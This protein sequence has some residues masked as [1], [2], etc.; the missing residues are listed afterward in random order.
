MHVCFEW[1]GIA[2]RADLTRPVDLST[3][4]VGNGEPNPSAWYVDST[5][6]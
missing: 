2:H 5:L 4:L 6:P 3:V 1:N